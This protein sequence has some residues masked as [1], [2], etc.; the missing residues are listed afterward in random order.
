MAIRSQSVED[1]ALQKLESGAVFGNRP[2]AEPVIAQK[3]I[4]TMTRLYEACTEYELKET[5][6]GI[7]VRVEKA[8]IYPDIKRLISGI[9]PMEATT[10]Y[11][12]KEA[13]VAWFMSKHRIRKMLAKYKSVRD[14]T[15]IGLLE[16]IRDIRYRVIMGDALNSHR[17]TH[18]QKISGS[19]RTITVGRVRQKGILGRLRA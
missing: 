6:K 16:E 3:D 15:A 18:I 17:A 2:T 5:S 10:T 1:L 13:R 14:D 11:M 4:E 12:I 9:A 7:P 8:D 19:D